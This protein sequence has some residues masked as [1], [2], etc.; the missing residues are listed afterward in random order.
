MSQVYWFEKD[1]AC[2]GCPCLFLDRDGVIVEEVN[3]LHRVEDVHILP[4]AA[5]LISAAHEHGWGVGLITN[6]GGIGRGYYDWAAFSAV[7]DEIVKCLSAGAAPFDFVAACA[8]HPESADPYYHVQNHSWRKPNTG[9]LQAAAAA[10]DLNLKASALVG[11]HLN[12]LRAAAR[13]GLPRL[14]HVRTGHGDEQREK[15]AEFMKD[16]EVCVSLVEN[17]IEVKAQLGW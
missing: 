11:D 12:D 16:P 1:K 15:V 17:L 7:Q 4:G 14:F 2:R 13:I 8:A 10:L 5:E 9:M 3:Y 6:Q